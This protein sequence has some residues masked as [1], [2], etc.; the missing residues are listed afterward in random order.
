MMI[1]VSSGSAAPKPAK[2]PWKRGMKK[3]SRK[4]STAIASVISTAG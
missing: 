3:T 2:I 1:R 4:I